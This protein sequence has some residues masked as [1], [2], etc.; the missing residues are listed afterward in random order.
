M[1]GRVLGSG[2]KEH[3]GI[4]PVVRAFSLG[5]EIANEMLTGRRRMCY[6]ITADILDQFLCARQ[7]ST[8]HVSTHLFLIIHLSSQSYRERYW[9]MRIQ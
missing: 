7:L 6:K 5:M 4:V 8:I 1:P 3:T 9:G 2:I